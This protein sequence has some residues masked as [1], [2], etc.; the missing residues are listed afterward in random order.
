MLIPYNVDRQTRRMPRFTYGL[1]AVNV[2]VFF[3]TILTSNINLPSDKIA[4]REAIKQWAAQSGEGGDWEES[5]EGATWWC[6][7]QC[8]HSFWFIFIQFFA[9]RLLAFSSCG[10]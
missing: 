8:C 2:L 6:Y 10:L 5:S 9:V 1:M 7:G 3:F 4:G